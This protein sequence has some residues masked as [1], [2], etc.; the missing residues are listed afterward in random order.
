MLGQPGPVAAL[1]DEEAGRGADR[2]MGEQRMA[3]GEG[4]DGIM[5]A[6]TLGDASDGF[7][8]LPRSYR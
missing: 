7:A 3:I 6:T 5:R 8:R 2:M 4:G 1:V